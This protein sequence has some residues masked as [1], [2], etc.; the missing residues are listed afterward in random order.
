MA[1][2]EQIKKRAME[3]GDERGSP[4]NVLK[5]LIREFPN[6]S[7]LP[8]ERT[9]RRWLKDKPATV[10]SNEQKTPSTVS[11]N[12]EE[13]NAKLA[14]VADKLLDSDLKRIIKRGVPRRDLKYHLYDENETDIL[15]EFTDEDLSGRLEENLLTV[16]RDYTDWFYKNCFIPHLFAEWSEDVQ[17]KMSRALLYD[18]PYLLIETLRLLAER[19]TFKGSCP[20]CKDWQ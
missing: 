12:W 10:V 11:G 20:V 6:E 19:K 15:E 1:H 14:S 2:P 9:I 5:A 13:H 16:Y 8:T 7:Y 4:G 17:T 3:L 18:E